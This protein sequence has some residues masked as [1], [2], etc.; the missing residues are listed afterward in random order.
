MFFKGRLMLPV[1]RFGGKKS[2]NLRNSKEIVT[3]QELLVSSHLAYCITQ[4]K[5]SS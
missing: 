4:L 5:S 1:Q 3:G 2:D